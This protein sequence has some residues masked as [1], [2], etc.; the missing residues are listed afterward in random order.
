MN[1]KDWSDKKIE[2]ILLDMPDIKDTRS[3]EEVLKKLKLDQI[4]KVPKKKISKWIPAVVAIAALLIF[5]I[6]LPSMLNGNNKSM[7]NASESMKAEDMDLEIENKALSEST[8]MKT[9]VEESASIAADSPSLF[10]ND[11]GTNYFP[12]VYKNDV[13]DGVVFHLGLASDA[14][15]NLPVTFI[16]SDEQVVE[17]FG[18][19]ELTS[20]D[21]YNM[22]AN[23][24]DEEALGFNDYHPYK[25]KLVEVTDSITHILPNGHGY[26]MASAAMSVY[27][28]TL[29]DTFYGFKEINFENED[30]TLAEFD[31]IGQ[32]SEPMQLK[33]GINQYNY[34][35]FK[36]EDGNEYLSPNFALSY[37]TLEKA[38]Q[39]MKIK[40]NDIY[41]PV[42]P[43]S[44]SFEVDTNSELTK[45]NFLEP[46]DLDSM[47]P[48]KVRQLVDGILL[49]AA[50]FDKQVQFEN[51]VQVEWNGFDFSKP[52]PIPV[53]P[54]NIPLL[55]K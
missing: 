13:L 52:L 17:D 44:V 23:K 33:N 1:N 7:D 18:E 34:Y 8:D 28:G 19:S 2:K 12:A 37:E 31:Q 35:L 40:P 20:L 11:N 32:L 51:V 43:E 50:S 36:Q 45:I 22:Y 55:L 25:G 29:H 4:T 39:E 15:S 41:S 6:L 26:D 5:S 49:T 27:F 16:L 54:N 42:I 14:A 53:G 38:L 47:D 24:L 9:S 30:G 46:L 10:M 3:K 48:K 21:L